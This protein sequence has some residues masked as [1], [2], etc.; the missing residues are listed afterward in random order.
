MSAEKAAP[1]AQT[2]SSDVESQPSK[3][4]LHV[5]APPFTFA[6]L[7]KQPVINPLNGKAQTLPIFN[8]KNPYSRNFHLSWLSF[9]VAFL[10]WFAF[11][12]LI[13]E[14]IRTD[15]DLTAA[16]I[17]NSNVTALA[18]TFL[19]RFIIGPFVDRFGPRWTMAALLILGAIPSGL[20][21]TINSAG[22]LYTIRFFIGI[23]GGTFVP[24]QAW[25][26]AF[27]DKN[28]VGT[29]NALVGGWGNLGGGVTFCVQVGLFESLT[30]QGLTDSQAWRAA[31]A[32]VPVPILFFVAALDIFFGTDCPAGKWSARHTLPASA[33]A[34]QQGH[35]LILDRNENVAVDPKDEAVKDQTNNATV[36]PAHD[37]DADK[38]ADIDVAVAEHATWKTAAKMAASPV[39]WLTPLLYMTSFGTELAIDANIA[40]V[41]Y[42]AHQSSDFGQLEAGFYGCASHLS[43]SAR[44]AWPLADMMLQPSMAS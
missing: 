25:T 1:S 32:V 18:S 28:I 20:A 11:P 14:A 15:L 16:Q 43:P 31:F 41:Y 19:V 6:S 12:P 8:L 9:F 13:P 40:N 21:G 39:T 35:Q 37:D 5:A 34:L 42:A 2:S 22:G 27:F 23:L 10:S 38:A 36:K 33:V 7:F 30:E 4:K 29:A 17:G 44:P 3:P 26:T 24:C